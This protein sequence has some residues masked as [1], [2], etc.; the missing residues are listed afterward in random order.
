MAV[1]WDCVGAVLVSAHLY[2]GQTQGLPL[3]VDS[4]EGRLV[5]R[6]YMMSYR[7][8][9]TD[10]MAASA[11]TKQL[12]TVENREDLVAPCLDVFLSPLH[13]VQKRYHLSNPAPVCFNRV[14]RLER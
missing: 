2:I 8:N 7:W 1:A 14:G 6:P 10:Q 3:Q 9:P 13:A 4:D 5:S 12:V 11:G